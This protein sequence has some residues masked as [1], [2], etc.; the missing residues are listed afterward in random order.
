M[1]TSNLANSSN[2]F[3]DNQL[4]IDLIANEIMFNKL[5][6]RPDPAHTTHTP[7]HPFTLIEA[8]RV[9]GPCGGRIV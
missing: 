6:A 3:G 4:K 9:A 5:Q 8:L 1:G 7:L 2:S